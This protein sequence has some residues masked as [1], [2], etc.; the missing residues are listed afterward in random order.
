MVWVCICG[1]E[2]NSVREAQEC[3]GLYVSER[4]DEAND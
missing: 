2:Y 1:L 3:C 4:E